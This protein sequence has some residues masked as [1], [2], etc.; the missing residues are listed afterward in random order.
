[1]ESPKNSKRLDVRIHKFVYV[2]EV[3]MYTYMLGGRL[4]SSTRGDYEA[5]EC[6]YFGHLFGKYLHQSNLNTSGINIDM[7]MNT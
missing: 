6:L 4:R 1:L 2:Y 5:C 3:H 7:Y